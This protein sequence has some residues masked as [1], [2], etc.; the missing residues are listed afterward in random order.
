M[1]VVIFCGGLGMRLREYAENVPKPMVPIGYRP[2]LW[3]V[4]KYYAH[5]GH[6][7]FILCLGHGAD[8][9][10]VEDPHE[11]DQS[12]ESGSDHALSDALTHLIRDRAAHQIQI[13]ARLH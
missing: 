10:K 6:K 9:I 12:R 5:Y 1:K 2:V 8:V 3:H 4:M 13:T 7:D 11:C